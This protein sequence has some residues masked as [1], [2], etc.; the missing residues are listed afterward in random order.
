MREAIR[1]HQRSSRGNHGSSVYL[2]AMCESAA[3][4]NDWPV[5]VPSRS[6]RASSGMA[7]AF[8][9]APRLSESSDRSR[10]S[11][12]TC[13]FALTEHCLAPL[14]VGMLGGE[15]GESDQVK[16]IR[17]M[18]SDACWAGRQMHE[19]RCRWVHSG[20]LRCTQCALRCNQ[21][22]RAQEILCNQRQSEVSICPPRDRTLIRGNH[23]VSI[24]PP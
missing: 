4:A 21:V 13:S 15:A 14:P 23:E 20:A 17:C 22:Q 6:W 1:G 18:R 12:V 16:S 8:A 11:L 2:R 10:T 19:I 7:P 24:C 3:P 5:G 9:S